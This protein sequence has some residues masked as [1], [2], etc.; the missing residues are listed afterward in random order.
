MIRCFRILFR[1]SS[2]VS[3]Q[4]VEYHS[5]FTIY[6][7]IGATPAIGPVLRKKNAVTFF[8]LLRERTTFVGFG[9]LWNTHTIDYYFVWVR[10]Y[11]SKFRL[12]LHYCIR[13]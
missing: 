5:A 9:L 12:V 6:L 7:S 1:I 11:I 4:T 10:T 8:E 13:L 3:R 2:V